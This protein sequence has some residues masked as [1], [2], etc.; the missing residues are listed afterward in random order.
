VYS[1]ATPGNYTLFVTATNDC[2]TNGSAIKSFTVPP[3]GQSCSGYSMMLFPN[4]T[5]GETT[6]SIELTSEETVF[7]EATEWELE[8]YSETQLL[9]EKII[10]LKGSTTIIQTAGWKEGVYFVRAKYKDEILQ[11]KLVVKK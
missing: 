4:P 5:T 9:K 11:G 2:G 3:L 7:D 1:N 10:N 6:L 8:I